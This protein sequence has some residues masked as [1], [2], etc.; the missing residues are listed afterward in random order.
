MKDT[1]PV[2]IVL[3]LKDYPAQLKTAEDYLQFWERLEQGLNGNTLVAGK[4]HVIESNQPKGKIGLTILSVPKQASVVTG[5]TCFAIHS[6]LERPYLLYKCK[7]CNE[8]G[9]FRCA[10][11]GC[12][13]RMCERHAA[14]LDGSMRAYCPEHAPKCAGSGKP[15][16]FWCDGPN[17]RG[18]VAWSNPYRVQHPNDADHWYCPQCYEQVFPACS[19]HACPDT[20]TA[21]C[22][23]ID[24]Y[25]GKNCNKPICNRHVNRWQIYGPQKLGA[26]LCPEHARVKTLTEDEILYQMVAITA[27]RRSKQPRRRPDR[28]QEMIT[29]PSL[30]SIRHIYINT[31]N[32]VVKP[33]AIN[34]RLDVFLSQLKTRPG[35]RL[36]QDMAWLIEQSGSRREREMGKVEL[37]LEQGKIIFNKLVEKLSLQGEYLLAEN[38]RFADYRPFKNLLFIYLDAQYRGRFI[39]RRGSKKIALQEYLGVK[40]QFEDK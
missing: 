40:I 25:T 19:V 22:E 9:P 18:R 10:E 36:A 24:R 37:Q 4:T 29:I 8:Y 23:F 5:D 16:T 27:R 32:K 21:R 1:A 13:N 11:K 38:V 39:G 28:P 15:A 3:D 7:V 14:I 34:S 17:C 30:M 6:V 35:D 12:E 2:E 33:E 20:G 31:Q 26:A